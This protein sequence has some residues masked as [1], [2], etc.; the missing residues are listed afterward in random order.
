MKAVKTRERKRWDLIPGVESLQ[1]RLWFYVTFR[2]QSPPALVVSL[3]CLKME[4]PALIASYN[5][6]MKDLMLLVWSM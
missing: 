6:G 1:S 4:E 3:R 5:V 2:T